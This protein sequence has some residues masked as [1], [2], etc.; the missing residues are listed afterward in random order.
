MIVFSATITL[1]LETRRTNSADSQLLLAIAESIEMLGRVQSENKL[2]K[3]AYC[4]LNEL[5]L[6]LVQ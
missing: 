3:E 2:A 1:T 5:K 6:D 4:I